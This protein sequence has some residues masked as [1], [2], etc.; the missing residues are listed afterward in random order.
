VL[1]G[2]GAGFGAAI[3]PPRAAAQSRT[4]RIGLIVLAP[5]PPLIDP[6]LAA[7][8]ARGWAQGRNLEVDTVVT[9]PQQERAADMAKTLIAKG[10]DLLVV[11]GTANAV[12]AQQASGA[13]PV[14]MLASGY[15]VQSGL[16]KTL[17]RPGGN[18]TG[19]TVYAGTEI[20]GK[21]VALAKELVPALRDLGVFWAYA[22]PAFPEIELEICRKEIKEAADALKIRVHFWMNRNARDLD[23]ALTAAA[24][25]PL[26]ALLMTSGGPQSTPEGIAKVANFCEKRRVPAVA[27]VAS[28]IFRTAGVAAYSPDFSELGMRGA[29]FVDRIFRGAKPG[30]LPIEHPTR[31]QLHINPRRAKLIG[32]TFPPSILARADRVIE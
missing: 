8:G 27:D 32:L 24:S 29:S 6:F 7:L 12:A 17:A 28:V 13:V 22:P 11:V 2:F 31:F 16:A 20:F 15:P 19:L 4:Y 25:A 26:Q 1:A 23:A 9:A 30:E 5:F 10:A 18:V 14:V 21:S 3:A